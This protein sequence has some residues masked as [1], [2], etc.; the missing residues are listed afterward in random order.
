M[1]R[2]IWQGT[3]WESTPRALGAL[4]RRSRLDSPAE[5]L[6]DAALLNRAIDNYTG[7]RYIMSNH[8]EF[9][10]AEIAHCAIRIAKS[11][12][13]YASGII[14]LRNEA[15]KFESSHQFRS[16]DA[17]DVLRGIE[18]QYFAKDAPQADTS[19]G[20]LALELDGDAETRERKA[21]KTASRPQVKVSGWF[22]TSKSPK[23]TWD[24]VFMVDT[25]TI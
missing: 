17:V 20:D 23:G 11:G 13:E 4:G 1:R 24:T 21:V 3:C 18:L 14:I 5:P 10:G 12:N 15:G 22:K 16:F 9:S 8:V 6:P 7:S 2:A 25:V 19:G